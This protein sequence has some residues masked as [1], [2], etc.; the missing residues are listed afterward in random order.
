M[1]DDAP[2]RLTTDEARA[3]ATECR[4]MATRTKIVSHQVMLIH[5]AETW[6]RIV[7]SM[8]ERKS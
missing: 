2:K 3:K 4:D 5:M 8:S 6:D 7:G 1:A